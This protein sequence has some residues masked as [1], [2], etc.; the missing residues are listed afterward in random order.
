MTTT[1]TTISTTTTD[2]EQQKLIKC[3]NN[4][5]MYI[6]N[7]TIIDSII[8]ILLT[9]FAYKWVTSTHG[10]KIIPIILMILKIIL[11]YFIHKIISHFQ[12]DIKE[13]FI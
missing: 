12:I 6:G 10:W 3:I 4:N 7:I 1:T 5:S 8:T 11:S 9:I 2:D 13:E